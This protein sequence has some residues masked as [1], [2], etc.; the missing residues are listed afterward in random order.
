MRIIKIKRKKLKK[1]KGVN[2]NKNVRNYK[3]PDIKD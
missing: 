1:E 3:H 2:N